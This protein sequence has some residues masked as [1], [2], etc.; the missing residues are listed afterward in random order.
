MKVRAM[1]AAA[2]VTCSL[3][4]LGGCT[5]TDATGGVPTT[6]VAVDHRAACLTERH[7]I[8]TAYHAV[9]ALHLADPTST[10]TVFDFLTSPAAYFVVTGQPTGVIRRMLAEVTAVDCPDITATE[11]V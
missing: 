1:V 8:I 6:T 9:A 7:S 5:P 4:V 11:L 2:T 10:A 3:A